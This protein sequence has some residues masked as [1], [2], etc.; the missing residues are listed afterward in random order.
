MSVSIGRSCF[1]LV[2]V[3]ALMTGLTVA[4][5]QD[6]ADAE[7]VQDTVVVWGTAV[8]SN[9]LYLGEGEIE[10][11]QADHLSDLLRTVPGVDIGGTHSVNSRINIRGLD[12]RNLNV[13]I[14]GA[15]QTNY[16]YHHMGNLLIN[17]DILESADVQLGA[18]TVTHGGI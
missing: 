7:S 10:L 12:D 18:N 1:G 6:A 15:L 5:A 11:K 8:T 17:A 2:A 9:S 16:L 3:S 13:Y 4:Q 14:D